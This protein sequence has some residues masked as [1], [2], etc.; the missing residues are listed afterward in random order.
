MNVNTVTVTI[1]GTKYYFDGNDLISA[2]REAIE[3]LTELSKSKGV[4]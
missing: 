2:E 1:K 3:F 4:F